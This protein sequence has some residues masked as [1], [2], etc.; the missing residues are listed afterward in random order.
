MAY[1]Y[2]TRNQICIFSLSYETMD[3]NALEE[4]LRGVF[5][6]NST[7]E[8][9]IYEIHRGHRSDCSDPE[10]ATKKRTEALTINKTSSTV[11]T[12]S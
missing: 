4:E 10:L 6:P 8:R 9:N 12:L 5:T 1:I 11:V 7:F 3:L 2:E